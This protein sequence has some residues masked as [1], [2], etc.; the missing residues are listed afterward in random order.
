MLYLGSFE[1]EQYIIHDFMG[2]SKDTG[3]GM[4]HV[5]VYAVAVSPISMIDDYGSPYL[6]K[7]TSA[8]E[9]KLNQ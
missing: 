7:L 1:G 2:Y 3:T 9:F 4:Q 8:L 5:Q 6:M